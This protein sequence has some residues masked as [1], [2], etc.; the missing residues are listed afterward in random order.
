M[1]NENYFEWIDGI[2]CYNPESAKSYDDYPSEGF[3]L[4][5]KIEASSFW[6]LSRARLL[7]QIIAKYATGK[8]SIRF[9]ELGCGTGFFIRELAKNKKFNITG[10]DIYLAGLKYAKE[11]LPGADF[12]QIDATSN[13]MHEQFDM[14]GAFDVIEHIEDDEMVIKNIYKSLLPKGYFIV[15]VPQYA[16]L[17][18]KLDDIVKHKRRYSR[19]ELLFKLR[20]GGFDIVFQS[21]FVFVLFPFMLISRL[22]DRKQSGGDHVSQGEMEERVKLP[23][24][25][26]WFFDKLMRID[27]FL[28]KCG[29]SLPVG[30]S[31]LVVAR[32]K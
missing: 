31:L 3:A 2:K 16:F 4:T 32:K 21:S 27:E 7:K 26:N 28:I 20:D 24:M 18:S 17:W 29:V 13:Y 30:G 22:L 9:L 5:D 25:I 10:S 11:K 15:T 19:T 1:I 23:K 6:C 8:S 12:V 14:I